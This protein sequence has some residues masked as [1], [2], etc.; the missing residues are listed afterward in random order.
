M[1]K[2]MKDSGIPWIGQIPEDWEVCKVKFL[3]EEIFSGGTPSTTND[4]YWNGNI[5]WLQSGKIQNDYIFE[6]DRTITEKGLENSST[7]MV[8]RDSILLAMTG[9]TCSNVGY[10]T[11]DS[12][13]NQSV[14]AYIPLKTTI[15]KF[16][17]YVLMACKN[18]ILL[19]KNGGAQSGINGEVCQNLFVPK[20]TTDLQQ[21]IVEI[22][23]KKCGQIDELIK[24]EEN[25]IEKL[26]EYKTSLITKVVTKGLD[27]NAKMKDSGIPWIGQIPQDWFTIKIKF[28]SWLKGRIGWDGLKS[29]EFKED[30]PFLITGTD[31]NNGHINWD[32]C[33]H[34][35]EERFMEDE[36]LHVKDGDLLITKDGTIGK[37]A[38]VKKCP[39]KVSLNSG[40]MIIRNNSNW[41][42]DNKYLYY[43]LLSNQFYLWYEKSQNGNSTIKHLY[44]EQFY[45][46]EFSYPNISYQKLIVAYLDKKCEE[47][48]NLLKIKQEKIE[49]LKEYKKSLIY[50]YLTGKKEVL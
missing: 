28:T 42:Y 14:M 36:L 25:A 49:K 40:V 4:S 3:C 2:K 17:F 1:I 34:I 27:P 31:F 6:Y 33:A 11:F 23:D 5:P 46:F 32:T 24:V 35:T 44:Q 12:C 20:I 15:P 16:L 48:D 10:L 7:K 41:R 39:E 45:N 26:K 21:K 37:L 8:K 18:N 47:I 29:S 30:G 38:I 50:Q 9:A 43:I 22:L 19:H 13:A